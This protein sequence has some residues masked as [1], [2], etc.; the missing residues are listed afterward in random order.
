MLPDVV[1]VMVGTNDQWTV[2]VSLEEDKESWLR[3]T[4]VHHSRLYE[5]LYMIRRALDAAPLVVETVQEN[6]GG[7]SARAR[8]GGHEFHLGWERAPYFNQTFKEKLAENLRFIVEVAQRRR[9][10]LVLMT[11][12]SAVSNYGDADEVIRRVAGETGTRLIDLAANFK[13]VCPSEPCARWLLRDH[14]PT[15]DGHHR[16]AET[17]L[18]ELR[19]E[20]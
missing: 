11:Y 1:T 9:V 20:L 7:G 19:N 5:L 10:K 18:R 13:E 16:V 14:H 8:Y 6:R 2:P 17:V 12:P 15:A 3:S 4:I